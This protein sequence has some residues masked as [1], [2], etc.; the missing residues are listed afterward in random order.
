[1]DGPTETP[2]ATLGRRRLTIEAALPWITTP[3]LLGMLIG[4]WEAY[5][6]I[7][8]ISP[9][10]LPR[11]GAV[12]RAWLEMLDDPRAW[13]HTWMTVYATL[14]GFAYATV[15]GVGLG[16]LIARLRWLELTLN[17]F[18]VATQVI[19]KVALV[20]LFVLWFGFGI[21]SKVIVAA[22]LAFF[23]ILTNTALGVKSI[24]EG[25]RDVMMSLNATRWQVFRRLEFPSALPYIITG[26]EIGIVLAIIG[27]VVGEYL[28][29]NS[30][31]GHLLIARLNAFETDQMFAVLI[32]MSMLGFLFYF[33]IGALRRA[34]VPWHASARLR[35]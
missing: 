30:G 25:H 15:I 6:H 29:G 23:P 16:V 26:L 17:P 4:L 13:H 3:I 32:H 34:L 20:P 28:G 33:A 24:E 35:V 27:S 2:P 7:G 10:I 12:W 18:I 14:S 1:M 31:L 9:L 21:T 11:P 19:P 8:G 5:I 22:V